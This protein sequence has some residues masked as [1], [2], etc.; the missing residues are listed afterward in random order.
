MVVNGQESVWRDVRSGVPQGS[1]LGPLLFVL[2]INDL[3]ECTDTESSLYLFADDNKLFRR[4]QSD[5]D[6]RSLQADLIRM[7][8]WT[9]KW[10]LT[11]HPDK[12]KYM[13]IGSTGALDAGY[14]L[15]LDQ[16]LP[17]IEIEKD[18]GVQIDDK[19]SFSN[20]ISEKINKA[21]KIMGLIRRT[22]VSLDKTSF[23]PLYTSLV[24]PILEYANQVWNP[25]LVKDIVA[26]ENVQRRATR[27]LP[28]MKDKPYEERLREVN[29]TSLSYRRSRGD[30]IETF[31]I[32]KGYYDKEVGGD[33]FTLRNGPNT[34]GHNWRIFKEQVRLNKRKNSFPIRVVNN[35]NSL[36]RDVVE[37]VSVDQFKR[38]LDRAWFGQDQKFNYRAQINTRDRQEDLV[39]E[40]LESQAQ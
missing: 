6:C 19:L 34:R 39:E 16:Q 7:K 29:L 20:H 28:G 5:Q 1:V 33:I 4:I 26:I 12:C 37:S 14:K 38:R 25:Y 17:R 27:M 8:E 22:F 35:W 24:R 40:D 31:K 9:D 36:H 2:F 15:D 11:F 13:R 3:L 18:L 30:M 21:N 32:I 10:L 23:V